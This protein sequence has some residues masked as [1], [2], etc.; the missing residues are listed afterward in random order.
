MNLKSFGCS[1]IFGSELSDDV[2]NIRHTTVNGVLIQYTTGSRLTWPAHLAKH[3]GYKYQP[4]ARPGSGNLQTAERVLSHLATNEQA[5]FVINWTYIDRFDYVNVNDPTKCPGMPWSTIMPV[6]TTNIA[7]TYYKN[8]HSEIRDK[9]TTLMSIRLVI[10][11]LKQKGCPFIMTYIDDLIFDTQWNT[12]PAITD[13]Q[14]Y[15]KPHMT[16]FKGVN[17]QQW[18]KKN[19]YPITPI[20]HPLEEAHAVAGQLMIKVFDTQNTI[21]H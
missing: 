19:G 5:F 8:L 6:D 18:S 1:F 21:D 15:I 7:N 2:Q 16:T 10:D 14:D 13:L 9:L 17:F 11:T 3:L 20:G 12:S 4:Y